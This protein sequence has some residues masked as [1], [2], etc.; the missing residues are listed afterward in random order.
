MGRFTES[1]YAF[2]EPLSTAQR[3]IFGLMVAILLVFLVSVFY[4]SLRPEYSL[5]FGSLQNESAREIVTELEERGISYRVEDNGRSIYVQS[6]EVHELRMKLASIGVAHSDVQGYEL[7]DA[8]ALGMTDFMQRVNKKR[9]LEGELSRSIGSLEQVDHARVHLVLPERTPFQRTSVEASA[10]IILTLNR[11]RSLD[12]AQVEGMTS[13]VAGSVE[14][15]DTK[16]ITVLDQNGNRLTDSA[17]GD[18]GFASGSRQIQLRE[19]TES[20]LTERGQS[21]LDRVLG[22]GNSIL[23][24]AAEHDFER[25]SRESDIIDPDSRTIISEERRSDNQTNEEYQQVPI[26]E[27]TPLNMRG[28]TVLSSMRNNENVVQTRNYEVNTIRELFEKPQGDIRRIS[29]SLLLNYKQALEENEEG[30]QVLVEEPYTEEELE[31]LQEVVRSAL[32]IQPDR[33]DELTITQIR[34]FDPTFDERYMSPEQPMPWNQVLRWVLILAALLVVAGLLY[35]MSKRFREETKPV[36]F[37]DYSQGGDIE[38]S[39]D[40]MDEGYSEEEGM[41]E[42]EEN[43]YNRKLSSE[44]RKQLDD[45]SFVVEEIRDFIELQPDDAASVVRA[46]MTM[47]KKGA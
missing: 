17:M 44:A 42:A 19:R 28:E 16:S 33:G 29:A 30:E 32:G 5:L 13:L 37:R 26:D 23:R 46:M 21:M 34:F 39:G 14:G 6:D 12:K 22:P 41:S 20:Y 18:E 9:A 31:D 4:W 10:S 27:F 7:F 36:L 24:V 15:L 8:N 3:T 45:K 43:F 47:S 25:L 35:N 1:V 38:I 40:D 2:F 11:G